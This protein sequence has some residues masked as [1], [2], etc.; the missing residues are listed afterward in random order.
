M[1]TSESQIK[2][3]SRVKE[4]GEVFTNPREVKAMCDL[5]PSEIWENIDSTFLEPTCGTGNFLVEIL[6]RKLK[7]CKTR[8]DIYLALKSI[9]AI[10]IMPD[11]VAES[12]GRMKKLICEKFGREFVNWAIINR[13]LNKNILCGDSLKIQAMWENEKMGKEREE[14]VLQK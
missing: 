9:Y 5:I 6:E 1:A 7:F 8:Q 12:K 3:R 13:I 11:N 10:D 4:K 14:N 2:S